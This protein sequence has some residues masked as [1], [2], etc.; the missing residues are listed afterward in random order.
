LGV[1]YR[2]LMRIDVDDVVAALLATPAQRLALAACFVAAGYFTL[3]F[4]DFIA[5][6]TLGRHWIPYGV[7][8][9]ASFTSYAIGHNV[10]AATLT[11]GTVRYRIYAAYGLSG[12]D[13]AKVCLLAGLTFS[14]GNALLLG[15]GL[16]IDPETATLIDQL[17][18]VFNRVLGSLILLVLA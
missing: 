2:V 14:L 15:L 13:V 10:G 1:L 7:A 9:L 3:T 17:P 8:A 16:A 6:R 12:V 11:G 4:Y 5:L 18:A